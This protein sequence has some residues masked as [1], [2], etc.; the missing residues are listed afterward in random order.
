MG[1]GSILQI[2]AVI[3][4]IVG[5]L[6]IVFTVMGISQGRP[7]SRSLVMAA[8]GFIAGVLLV[9][10]GSGLL[11]IG[12]NQVAVIYN[13]TTGQLSD[14][15]GPGI[16]LVIPGLQQY[17]IYPTNEQEYTISGQESDDGSGDRSVTARSIDG[18][19]VDLDATIYFRIPQANV[20]RI[21]QDWS[22]NTDGYINFIRS[23]V[24][25]VVRDAVSNFQAEEI[26]GERRDD[27]QALIE[28]DLQTRL[29]ERGFELSEFL[30]RNVT[31]SPEF[32]QAIEDKQIEQQR[33][34]QAQTA[35]QRR[36]AEARGS[37][38]AA[39]ETARGEAEARLVEARAEAEGLRLISEQLAANPNLLQYIYIQTLAP[40][41]NL[42]IIPSNSP[43]L[44]DSSTFSELSPDF[45]PP[46]V[47]ELVPTTTPEG[48]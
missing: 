43:F 21:H 18:Q 25:S 28:E 8:A 9:V 20:N 13:P 46:T 42:A 15:K 47:P 4:F 32:T 38:N 23:V 11:E 31:F 6:G 29:T 35:A 10:A 34:E 39:I 16:H 30:L 40:N 1:V 2:L 41:I 24:R 37:A 44:F 7:F 36:E 33:L 17:T 3:S 26:Y 45:V 48:E 14:P 12:V 27:L 19:T 5:I 22:S